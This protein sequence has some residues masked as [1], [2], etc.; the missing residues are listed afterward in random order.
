MLLL[1]KYTDIRYILSPASPKMLPASYLLLTSSSS[2]SFQSPLYLLCLTVSL[3]RI[4]PIYP[5]NLP[6]WILFSIFVSKVYFVRFP[7]LQQAANPFPACY[8]YA[9]VHSFV[10][11]MIH[12]ARS[13]IPSPVFIKPSN[14]KAIYLFK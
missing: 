6:V 7:L 2:A 1:S 11:R 3:I 12:S 13:S 8:N 4:L 14:H 10:C 9:S 5:Q